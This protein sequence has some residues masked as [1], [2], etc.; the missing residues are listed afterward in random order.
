MLTGKEERFSQ[1]LALGEVSQIAAYIDA[2]Y[3]SAMLRKG[4][5]EKACLYAAKDKI[6]ARVDAIR[7]LALEAGALPAV[8]AS[9]T[10][11]DRLKKLAIDDK[12]YGAGVRCEELR[13]RLAGHYTEKREDV[14]QDNVTAEEGV[15][16]VCTQHGSLNALAYKA[17][18]EM[19]Q[20]LKAP[21]P[22]PT[23]NQ[24]AP[25]MVQ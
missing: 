16:L 1:L 15:R 25:D 18:M 23:P 3:S 4:I 2:G 11:L 10:E 24:P 17:G 6:R 20:H 8:E 19:L 9:A 14:T 7:Q 21:M 12:N 22:E 13:G 5:H